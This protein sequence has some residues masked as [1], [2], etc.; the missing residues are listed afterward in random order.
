MSITIHCCSHYK[1]TYNRYT[2]FAPI[3]YF[4]REALFI[5]TLAFQDTVL[6]FFILAYLWIC[7]ELL[8]LFFCFL[9]FWPLTINS[10]CIYFDLT[11]ALVLVSL[12]FQVHETL[13]VAGTQLAALEVIFPISVPGSPKFWLV[14]GHGKCSWIT[15]GRTLSL[16][17]LT[18]L[19]LIKTCFYLQDRN[20][21]PFLLLSNC[22]L[23][24]SH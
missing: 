18:Q 15:C 6:F 4:I 19:S 3:S 14:G 12:S 7:P 11:V 20:W 9:I 10:M 22:P 13:P 8:C 23:G 1:C 17:T 2:L 16:K 21:L 24:V 5:L